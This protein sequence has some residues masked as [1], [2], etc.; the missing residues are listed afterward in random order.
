MNDAISRSAAL[1]SAELISWYHANQNGKMVSGASSCDEAYVKFSDVIAVLDEAKALDV[2]PVVHEKG[3]RSSVIT[4][5]DCDE[6]Q[7]RIIL[8]DEATQVCAVYY[9]DGSDAV[10]VV[11]C[12]DCVE[13]HQW[14]QECGYF[15]S[16]TAPDDYCSEGVRKDGEAE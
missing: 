6:W 1:E 5:K 10:P 13:Y 4:V 12:K 3:I 11:R 2:A 7:N 14:F 16:T 8:A 9:A 15:Q